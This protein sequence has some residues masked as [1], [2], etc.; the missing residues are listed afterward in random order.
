MVV[1]PPQTNELACSKINAESRQGLE[2]WFG[3]MIFS[4]EIINWQKGN[5]KFR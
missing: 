3:Q 4:A 2:K 1:T 5:N